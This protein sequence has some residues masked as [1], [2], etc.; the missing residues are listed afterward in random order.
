[1]SD[2]GGRFP[3]RRLALVLAAIPLVAV[4]IA[5]V[6]V[7][8]DRS[9]RKATP[10]PSVS[11]PSSR[12]QVTTTAQA[13]R[14]TASS[15]VTAI[16][17]LLQRRSDAVL[18]HN[19]AEWLSTIDPA[20][21]KFRAS[22]LAVFNNL[23]DVKFASWS[24]SFDPADE[25]FPAVGRTKYGAVTWAPADFSLHYR[26]RNF[27]QRPT[28]LLQY[29]TFVERNGAW[30]LASLSDFDHRGDKS[31]LDIWDF[32]PVVTL[33]TGRVL[34]LGHPSSRSLLPGIAAEVVSDIPRVSKV[35]GTGWSQR[36]VVL[37][38]QTQHELGAVVG[39]YG[40][41]KHIAAVA[42][43][44]VNVG[45]GRPNPVGDR[46]AINP[47]NW[48]K[49]S[50]LGRRI[51]LTHE[52]THVATRTVTSAATPTWLAEGFADYVGYQDTGI[53]VPFIAQDL[54][55]DVRAGHEPKALPA[56]GQFA[57]TSVRLSQAYEGAWLACQL[58]AHDYGQ[59]V[60][61]RFY[62]EV[63][64]SSASQSVAVATAMQGV[65]HLTPRQFSAKWRAYVHS[66]LG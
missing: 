56:S 31:S 28:N 19:R 60:L 30:L 10:A 38:P 15:R 64:H 52:L 12:P 47:F 33:Q 2:S 48:P 55:R 59:P 27:D 7:V 11:S 26:L 24:Y 53:P 32:G 9:T 21:R 57:G 61:V 22:Q 58:I 13:E 6:A 16:R 44:E 17:A 51:V 1:M 62:R 36:A 39:D 43:A 34:V 40:N 29:P 49:L 23:A 14:P 20:E 8:A 50:D 18:H 37:V 41:L 4:A 42:S 3:P 25:Q 63:G 54:A 35:W 45:S 65:L 66:Q 46:I 5:D